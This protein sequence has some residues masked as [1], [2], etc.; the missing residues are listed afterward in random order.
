MSVSCS[1]ACAALAA[2]FALAPVAT[3]ATPSAGA[4]ATYRDRVADAGMAPDIAAVTVTQVDR[5]TLTVTVALAAP[6]DLGRYDW[7]LIGIDTDRNQQTGGMHGSEAVVFVN[8]ERAV[9][10]RVGGRFSPVRAR[11]TPTELVVTLAFANLGARTF[12]FAVA[13]LRQDAD[14]AP[15]RGVFRY[16]A[17]RSAPAPAPRA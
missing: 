13:T 15:D 17:G 4:S 1:L 9:L 5:A 11:L 12:D 3:G 14:V 6:T 10:S 2:A 16:P 8:G 7:I